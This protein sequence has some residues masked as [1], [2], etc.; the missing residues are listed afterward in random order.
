M[1]QILAST[2]AS[3]T[4]LKANPMK[5]IEAAGD[6]PVAILNRNK[7]AFYCLSPERYEALMDM[8]DDIELAALVRE[9]ENDERI[10]VAWEDL[11]TASPDKHNDDL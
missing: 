7:P 2:A 8:I 9:R 4:E 11:I 1:Y 6:V 3:I 5:V 10:S